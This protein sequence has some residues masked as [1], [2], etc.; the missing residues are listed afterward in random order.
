ME[1]RRSRST[2]FSR[3]FRLVLGWVT[4]LRPNP[5]RSTQSGHSYRARRSLYR[6]KSNTQRKN[7]VRH[8]RLLWKNTIMDAFVYKATW[9]GSLNFF[10]MESC[11]LCTAH[12]DILRHN[13]VGCINNCPLYLIYSTFKTEIFAPLVTLEFRLEYFKDARIY[14]YLL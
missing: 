6:Q 10:L 5:P 11:I 3:R 13:S 12:L 7:T 4:H 14:Y 1:T 2:R 8:C 9:F